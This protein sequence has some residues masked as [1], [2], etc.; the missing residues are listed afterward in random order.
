M[1]QAVHGQGVAQGGM[2][3]HPGGVLPEAVAAVQ[4][5]APTALREALRQE[6]LLPGEV[7]AEALLPGGEAATME[8][9]DMVPVMERSIG[10]PG[11]I[12]VKS[13]LAVFF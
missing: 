12:T 8:V 7:L 6:A 13:R 5:E 4:G 1:A 9:G 11:R 3:A 10:E 2:E